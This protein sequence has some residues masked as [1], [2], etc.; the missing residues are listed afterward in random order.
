MV[1]EYGAV[2]L[3]GKSLQERA[4]FLIPIA[5]PDDRVMLDRAAF[6]RYGA[7]WNIMRA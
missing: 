4:K 2:N 1:I 3:Y 6:E 5:L 7:H